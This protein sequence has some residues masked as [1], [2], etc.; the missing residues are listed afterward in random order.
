LLTA[1]MNFRSKRLKTY[2]LN[3]GSPRQTGSDAE[4]TPRD[5]HK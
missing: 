5:A 4:A 1:Q 3:E 2:S